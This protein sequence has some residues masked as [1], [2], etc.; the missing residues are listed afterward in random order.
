MGRPAPSVQIVAA[1]CQG[2]TDIHQIAAGSF[3]NLPRFRVLDN[4]T[5]LARPVDGDGTS[6]HYAE[7]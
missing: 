1:L 2:L 7:R 6:R 3:A 5:P 4:P